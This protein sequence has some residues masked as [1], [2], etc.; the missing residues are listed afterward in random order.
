MS[1]ELRQRYGIPQDA[2]ITANENGFTW[3]DKPAGDPTLE[4]RVAALERQMRG[5]AGFARAG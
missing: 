2:V 3:A 4:Q 1:A 5:L